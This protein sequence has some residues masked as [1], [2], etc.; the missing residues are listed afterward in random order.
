[1]NK[2]SKLSESLIS[3][4]IP[5]YN[6]E[7]F[8]REAIESVFNQSYENWELIIVDDGSIDKSKDIVRQYIRDKRVKLVENE[9]NKGI[10]KTKNRGLLIA[11]GE[12]VAFLD[13]DDIW[14]RHKLESQL[15]LFEQDDEV[16]LVCTGMIFTDENMKSRDIFNGF[17]D[18]DQQKLLKNLYL[19]P[20][21]SS[22]LMMVKQECFSRAGT[23]D[24]D[25][26]GWDDYEFLMRI[27]T[28]F[29]IKYIRRPL[30]K[31]RV[32][33]K[34]AQL[35][36]TVFNETRKVFERVLTLHPSLKT[37]ESTKEVTLLFNKSIELLKEGK[38]GLV[39]KK[40]KKAM[41]IKP[42]YLKIWVLYM[43][44]ALPGQSPLKVIAII[45]AIIKAMNRM[46][47]KFYRLY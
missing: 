40:L 27:A 19:S 42:L 5:C 15:R 12:Y 32:H 34:S 47:A 4:I 18:V 44:S 10:P 8:I 23:F 31:K 38:M 9:C 29:R 17:D 30:V 37:Y 41:R 46:K 33:S 26:K 45:S 7:K 11:K 22:S 35:T 3:I 28:K 20:I 16:G 25:I 6:G 39:R 36:P 24:E 14:M 21:N 43:I 2:N 13:Q 1:M